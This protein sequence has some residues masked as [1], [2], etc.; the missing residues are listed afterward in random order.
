MPHLKNKV[1]TYVLFFK[2]ADQA[3]DWANEVLLKKAQAIPGIEAVL[4]IGG[5]EADQ[6]DARTSGQ[7]TL[8]NSAGV[9]M[10]R[11]GITPGRGHMGDGEGRAAILAFFETGAIHQE[12]TPIFGCSIKKPERAIAGAQ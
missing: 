8:F 11:G 10:F 4:D 1:K 6:F 2:P 7:V 9:L 5:F 3:E 12:A